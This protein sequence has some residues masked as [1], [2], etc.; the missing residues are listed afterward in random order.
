MIAVLR[1]SLTSGWLGEQLSLAHLLGHPQHARPQLDPGWVTGKEGGH[2]QQAR[3]VPQ[4]A[5]VLGVLAQPR[6][7]DSAHSSAGEDGRHRSE[8]WDSKLK[9][10]NLTTQ[11][12]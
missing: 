3:G 4:R 2:A 1:D 12:V 8:D 10:Y 7:E 9:A 11:V 5:E 6:A